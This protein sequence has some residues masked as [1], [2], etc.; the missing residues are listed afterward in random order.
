MCTHIQ[1]LYYKHTYYVDYTLYIDHIV[2]T[3]TQGVRERERMNE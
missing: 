2:H 1:H 3:Y